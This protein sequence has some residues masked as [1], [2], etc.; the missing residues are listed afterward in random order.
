MC[1][2]LESQWNESRK[3]ALQMASEHLNKHSEHRS[4]ALENDCFSKRES[5]LELRSKKKYTLFKLAKL[6]DKVNLWDSN[7]INVFTTEE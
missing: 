7:C 4:K 2:F 6:S 3:R 5:R 1:F